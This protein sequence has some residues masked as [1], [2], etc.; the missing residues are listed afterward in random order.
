MRHQDRQIG[1][2]EDVLG[3]AAQEHLAQ[4]AVGVGPHDKQFRI[5]FFG[6][7]QQDIADRSLL[8]GRDFRHVRS[9]PMPIQIVRQILCRRTL[10]GTC[11]NADNLDRFRFL[12]E[13]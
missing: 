9:D 10:L 12:Q 2:G 1:V 11:D 5:G 13:R 6:C 4:T 3:H 7:L 8:F